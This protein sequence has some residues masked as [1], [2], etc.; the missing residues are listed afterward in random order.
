MICGHSGRF[1]LTFHKVLRKYSPLRRHLKTKCSPLLE[2]CFRSSVVEGVDHD[3]LCFALLNKVRQPAAHVLKCSVSDYSGKAYEGVGLQKSPT[4]VAHIFLAVKA[5]L[6]PEV[7]ACGPKP[8]FCCPR[9]CIQRSEKPRSRAGDLLSREVREAI[10]MAW[11]GNRS[12]SVRAR[13]SLWPKSSLYV[14]ECRERLHRA[15]HPARLTGLPVLL[16]AR[17]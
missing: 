14:T 7:G 2:S 11:R 8:L 1:L 12:H 10:S 15:S 16:G 13:W 9:L 17:L 3:V 4:V 5:N 6:D